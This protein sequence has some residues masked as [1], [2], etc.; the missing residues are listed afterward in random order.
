MRNGNAVTLV[1]RTGRPL[2]GNGD[3][4]TMSNAEA[5]RRTIL[6]SV[7]DVL[8]ERTRQLGGLQYNQDRDVYKVAGYPTD[9][10]FDKGW[11]YYERDGLAK[12]IVDLPVSKTW[13]HKPDL[14]VGEDAEHEL[15]ETFD[16]WWEDH[17]LGAAFSQ[18]D[19]LAS[20]GRFSVL[21][22]GLTGAETDK[23]LVEP[24]AEGD[25]QGPDDLLY[26][27]AYGEDDVEVGKLVTDPQD[28]RR[29]FPET[30]KIDFGS[31][32]AGA[33]SAT[34]TNVEVHWTRV[35]HVVEDPIGNGVYGIPRLKP[36]INRLIDIEKL[37]AA[38][39]EAFWQLAVKILQVSVDPE[40]SLTDT[41]WE[42][43]DDD[44]EDLVHDLRR[45]FLGQGVDMEFIG[46]ES[47][48]PSGAADL[49]M[50]LIAASA[51]I[52]KRILFGTETGERASEQDERAFLGTVAERIEQYAD[53]RIA[54]SFLKRLMFLGAV[55]EPEGEEEA[56]SFQWKPLFELSEL[57]QAERNQTAAETAETLTPMGGNPRRQ[58]RVTE[59]REVELLTDAEIEE[60]DGTPPGEEPGGEPGEPALPA[61]AEGDGV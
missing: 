30:Y 15:G 13:R 19:R 31:D 56:W 20:V 41:Q 24:V 48:D 23:Q 21:F 22:L 26:V 60:R 39:G 6:N 5:V 54:R 59:A 32:Q 28:P 38:T 34:S 40:A 44:M 25:V 49:L 61:G 7:G 42:N 36:I 16:A 51:N 18:V 35:V 45:H 46:G 2:S 1:D 53:P 52:P 50:M 14:L 11:S 27:R 43:L 37:A 4:R 8:R 55:D 47:P 57:Q 33:A 12:R 9:Y 58:V 29:G 10:T 17:A 3:G